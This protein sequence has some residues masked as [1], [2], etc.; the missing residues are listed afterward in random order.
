MNENSLEISIPSTNWENVNITIPNDCT[1][2]IKD[3]KIILTK[4]KDSLELIPKSWEELRMVSGVYI[5][6]GSRI[7][8][9]YNLP[10]VST[11]KST[12]PLGLGSS[13]LALIQLLQLR[14]K[15]WECTDSKPS[16]T[17]THLIW[18]IVPN[19]KLENTILTVRTASPLHVVAVNTLS[20]YIFAF[21]KETVAD[22]FLKYHSALLLEI[23]KLY[24][25]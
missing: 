24:A 4:K 11:N 17:H 23:S 10:A 15:T 2:E 8:I 7:E 12:I 20:P 16:D 3:G 22:I 9:T 21:S 25:F 18:A 13:V 5:S 6:S 1:S 14:N 19:K